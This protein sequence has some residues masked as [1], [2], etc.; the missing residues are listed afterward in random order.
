MT[1][2]IQLNEE[3]SHRLLDYAIKDRGINFIDTAEMYPVP[4][5]DPSWEPGRTEEII[6][7]WLAK[8]PEW[9]SK[10]IIATKVA[11]FLPESRVSA[12]RT[13]K[14]GKAPCK[15]DAKSVKEAVEASL[16]RLQTSYI[17]LYQVHW[18]DRY[19]PIFG[20]TVFNPKNVRPTVPISE[21]LQVLA[22]LI[23]EKK[24][25]YYG[26]SNE[27]PY[28][29]GE[30][31]KL[32]E[33][34]KLPAPIS[35]Q[36]SFCLL[37]RSFETELAESCYHYNIPLLPWGVLAGG[38]LS[39]K[40]IDGA[41]P[42]GTRFNMWKNFQERYINENSQKSVVEYK[43]VADEAGLTLTQLSLAFCYPK[44][45]I[46]STIIGG[47]TV[48]QLKDNID[49]FQITLNEETLK[50]LDKIYVDRKDPISII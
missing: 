7:K 37:H 27:T 32:S 38:V 49:A 11:G 41:S 15:L 2:G 26:L 10:I 17:D 35:I 30:W 39:G 40:Y 21:T 31:V 46:G 8:N 34:L 23:N 36:N 29:V 33:N 16:K 50:K 14:P 28:G 12:V 48:E 42:N 19:I 45:F 13:E 47:N 9:R 43:K 18:P 20:S 4:T 5:T 3:Q 22:E 24:I 25:R 44:W 6:G 1:F